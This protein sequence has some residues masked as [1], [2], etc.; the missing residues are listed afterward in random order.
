M[1][2][3]DIELLIARQL[4]DA[5]ITITGDDGVHF[6]AIIVTD[7]FMNKKTIERQKMVY[8]GVAEHISSGAIHALSLK[9]YTTAEWQNVCAN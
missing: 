9:T 7:S 2:A 8:K 6:A 1:L 4:P 3:K 5:K